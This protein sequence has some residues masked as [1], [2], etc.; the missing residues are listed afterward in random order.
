[1]I[2]SGLTFRH[3]GAGRPVLDGVSFE[4][5]RGAIN[6]ILGPN[7]SGKTTLFKCVAGLWKPQSGAVSYKN[8][9][10]L[11][12]SERS[13][14]RLIAV[15]PQDHEPPFPYSVADVVLMGRAAHVGAFSSPGKHDLHIADEA[16]R[17]LE[18]DALRRKPYTQISGGERQL[19]LVARALAQQSPI[20]LLD[21]P[22]SHLDFRNQLRV[23]LKVREIARQR[24][25]TVLMT[26]HDPNLALLFADNVIVLAGGKVQ[27]HGQADQVI[28]TETMAAVYGVEVVVLQNNGT[29]VISPKVA[30]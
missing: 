25:I 2:V 19:V 13:R 20:L 7:G 4:A 26:L 16:L 23:L 9:Q 1:M 24:D 22:T 29:R 8:H 5:R 18:L 10:V 28:T 30:R 3:P 14:S 6:V 17:A 21:E 15:V 12:L 11:S 27:S